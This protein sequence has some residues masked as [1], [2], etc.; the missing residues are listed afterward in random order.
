MFNYFITKSIIYK[1]LNSI[2][3]LFIKKINYFTL[4]FSP[5]IKN[6]SLKDFIAI[7]NVFLNK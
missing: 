3:S 4:K 7:N 2:N 5:F 1:D 6:Y